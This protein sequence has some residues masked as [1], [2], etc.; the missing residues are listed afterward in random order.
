LLHSKNGESDQIAKN[1]RNA[2]TWYTGDTSVNND[3]IAAINT[4]L[5]DPKSFILPAKRGYEK[6][7]MPQEEQY[8]IRRK[9]EPLLRYME[10]ARDNEP[11]WA[12]LN[13]RGTG[14]VPFEV[15]LPDVIAE[16]WSDAHDEDVTLVGGDALLRLRELNLHGT[17]EEDLAHE[18]ETFREA[19]NGKMAVKEE[20]DKKLL[21]KKGKAKPMPRGWRGM[22]ALHRAVAV[23]TNRRLVV[24]VNP[25]GGEPA[26]EGGEKTKK[27]PRRSGPP[28]KQLD[29]LLDEPRPLPETIVT[30]TR[31]AKVNWVLN[32]LICAD[33]DE[34]FIIFGSQA[35]LAAI[36][37]A[38]EMLDIKL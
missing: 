27:K 18:G 12:E 20:R 8:E 19:R 3:R 30:Y 35:E 34:K 11:L 31:S 5:E 4:W 38:L 22:D 15:E 10:D 13:G 9:L 16:S 32:T 1:L 2:C 24:A 26:E 37:D 6:S 28:T 25:A 33:A 21:K 14:A 36:G 29:K 7:V 23:A 17:K